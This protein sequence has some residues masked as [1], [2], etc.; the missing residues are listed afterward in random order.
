ML[1]MK[2]PTAAMVG[3]V[4]VLFAIRMGEA[5]ARQRGGKGKAG[6]AHPPKGGSGKAHALPPKAKP[7][8]KADGGVTKPVQ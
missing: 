1:A 4:L 3:L 2:W 7:Q 8:H 6:P 5:Q